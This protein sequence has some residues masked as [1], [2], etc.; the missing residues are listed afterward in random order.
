MSVLLLE[1]KKVVEVFK[2][3]VESFAKAQFVT[4][5]LKELIPHAKINFDLDDCDH[6]LR[7]EALRSEIEVDSIV[8]FAKKMN[9]QIEVLL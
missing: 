3:D 5:N 6:I 2:T 7:I 4:R 9:I 1:N 8:H